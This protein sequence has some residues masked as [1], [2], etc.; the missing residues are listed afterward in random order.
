MPTPITEQVLHDKACVICGTLFKPNSGIHK[1]CSAGCKDKNNQLI[2]SMSV[3]KQYERISGN[4][5]AYL[6]RLVT[7]KRKEDGLTVEDLLELLEKQNYK[8]ALSGVHLTCLLE[9]GTVFKTNASLDRIDAGGPYVIS[10]VQL[11]CRAVNSFR[12][13]T[14]LNEFIW[15]CKQVVNNAGE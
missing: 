5:K 9:V 15:W 14:N 3:E 4:W 10:N 8:C 7:S 1:F 2:G 11:V 12:N 13:N 6:T